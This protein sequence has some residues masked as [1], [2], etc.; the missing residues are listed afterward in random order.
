VEPEIQVPGQGEVGNFE[1][2]GM[3]PRAATW[4]AVVATSK[5]E[6]NIISGV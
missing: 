3:L 4:P 6:V 2:V 1:H 5:E